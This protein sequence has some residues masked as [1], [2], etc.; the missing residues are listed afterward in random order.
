MDKILKIFKFEK[1]DSTSTYASKLI[2]E[3]TDDF[4]VIANEQTQG[5]GRLGNT[6]VSP[7]GGVYFTLAINEK[8]I[9][10]VEL[11]AFYVGVS[12]VSFFK[13]NYN[14]N[15]NIKWVNDLIYD[16]KKVGG[17]L[18]ERKLNINNDFFILIGI[19]INVNQKY[20]SDEIKDF[21]ISINIKDSNENIINGMINSIYHYIKFSKEEILKLY[22]EVLM[23]KGLE[24]EFYI[25]HQQCH[26]IV[27]GIDEFGS[28]IVIG[29][30]KYL[31]NSGVVS[32]SSKKVLKK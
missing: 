27:Q 23:L 16:N 8:K 26:G 32:L 5:R 24:I 9:N 28:L 29:E 18:C 20:L 31:L 15:L 13:N 21:A 3:I 30:K 11:I 25:D 17:I 10:N 4:V 7:I 1:I 12:I 6:F 2:N 22:D 19:G 14:V